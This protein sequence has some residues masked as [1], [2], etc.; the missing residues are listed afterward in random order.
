MLLSDCLHTTGGDPAAALAGIDRLHVLCPLPTPEAEAAARALAAR[1][2]G[3]ART[4]RTVRGRRP[5]ADRPAGLTSPA[6]ARPG[7]TGWT[8]P[9]GRRA[10]LARRTGGAR[11][12]A[13]HA[14][15]AVRAAGR[16]GG[17]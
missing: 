9:A 11:G 14:G 17:P 15:R 12:R 10:G 8:G 13:A 7:R 2:G 5:G 4:V 16:A 1:G 3:A 6:W